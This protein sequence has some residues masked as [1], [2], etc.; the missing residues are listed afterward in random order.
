M[1]TAIG[2]AATDRALT[3]AE[4]R[5]LAMMAQDGLAR[6]IRPAHT[7]MDGD[8]LFALST[9]RVPA[10]AGR[11]RALRLAAVGSAAAD[12]VA[13]SVARAVHAAEA[14]PGGRPAWR[15]LA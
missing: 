9:E 11:E 3:P 8:T 13:R 2:L 1:L 6:A 4:C 7:P 15:D 5:R 10:G 12:C 14:L